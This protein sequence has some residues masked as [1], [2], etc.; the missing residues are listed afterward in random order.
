MELGNGFSCT[1]AQVCPAQNLTTNLYNVGYL[2]QQQ[3]LVSGNS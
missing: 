1:A 3:Q 2:Q